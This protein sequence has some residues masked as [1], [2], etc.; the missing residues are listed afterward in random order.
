[1]R[2]VAFVSD[3]AL[4]VKVS[5]DILLASPTPHLCALLSALRKTKTIGSMPLILVMESSPERGSPWVQVEEAMNVLGEVWA[6]R[7][8]SEV[9]YMLSAHA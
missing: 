5:F 1:M 9:R 3:V 6:R 7:E 4:S 8:N 2:S